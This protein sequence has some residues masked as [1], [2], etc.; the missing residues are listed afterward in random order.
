MNFDTP[1]TITY[2]GLG[3]KPGQT[4]RITL[5]GTP[6]TVRPLTHSHHITWGDTTHTTYTYPDITYDNSTATTHTWH[7]QYNA[8]YNTLNLDHPGP[9]TITLTAHH[10]IQYRTTPTG[11][12]Q[13]LT[14]TITRQAPPLPLHVYTVTNRLYNPDLPLGPPP[15]PTPPNTT[16]AKPP[17]TRKRD[18]AAP[19]DITGEMDQAWR[20]FRVAVR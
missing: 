8:P 14:L 12:W 9:A 5:L 20:V 19:G 6:I 11:P 10:T 2:P 18:C 7:H 15:T 13:N 16:D 17:E 1:F 4:T 3:L